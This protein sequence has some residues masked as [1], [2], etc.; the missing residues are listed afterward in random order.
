MVHIGI[1]CL[2]EN[3]ARTAEQ[4]L[5]QASI[6][7]FAAPPRAVARASLPGTVAFGSGSEANRSRLRKEAHGAAHL[8]QR[9]FIN[10]SGGASREA[11]STSQ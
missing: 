3:H 5:A 4:K 11:G 9:G 6:R 7:I 1:R 8:G 10:D 2:F